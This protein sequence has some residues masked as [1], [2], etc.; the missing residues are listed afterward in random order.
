MPGQSCGPVIRYLTD[1][2]NNVDHE[3]HSKLAGTSNSLSKG[4]YWALLIDQTIY[5]EYDKF[6]P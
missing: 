6:N 5:P 2:Q 1:H 3:P 4:V